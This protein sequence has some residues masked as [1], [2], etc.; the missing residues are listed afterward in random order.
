[1]KE[2]KMISNPPHPVLNSGLEKNY[3]IDQLYSVE[4]NLETLIPWIKYLEPME[5]KNI[6][7]F[8]T[9]SGGTAVACALN[10]DKGKVTGVDINEYEI[11]KAKIR[12]KAYNVSDKVELL[13]SVNTS[14][15]PYKNDAFDIVIIESVIEH[16]VDE[17][18]KYIK[19]AFRIL[20]KGGLMVISGTPNLLYPKDKHTTNLYFI[21]WLKSKTAKKYAVWRKRWKEKDDLDFAGR[22]GTTYW[23]L[24]K[25]LNEFSYVIL[26]SKP[27]FTSKY[28]RKSGRINSFKR[29]ILFTPY[30]ILEYILTG[31]FRLPVTAVMPYLNHIFIRKN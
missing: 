17:R 13:H 1:M 28:L 19:E 12:A 21:P 31:I 14:H 20:K 16:I 29:K 5:D 3:P 4:S 25:W 15:L 23:H 27:G 18:G 9:G 6:F 24:K 7:I 2:K 30:M 11:E 26:N 10:V 22:K 8:G